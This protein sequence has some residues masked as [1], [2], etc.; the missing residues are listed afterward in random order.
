MNFELNQEQQ[1]LAD[2]LKRFVTMHESPWHGLKMKYVNPVTGDYA[3][4]TIATFIQLLP[5]GFQ[6]Q[7]YRATDGTVFVCVEGQ[8]KTRVG[9]KTFAWGPRDVFVV[10]SWMTYTHAASE[11]AVLFSFSDRSAQEKLG[12]FRERKH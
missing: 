11:D 5:K 3:I 1:L 12:L 2:S 6:T 9:D 4:Q 7:P 8:G 10:P